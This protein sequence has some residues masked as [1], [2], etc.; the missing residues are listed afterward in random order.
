MAKAPCKKTN[1]SFEQTLWDTADKLR[2]ALPDNYFS[3]L[4]IDVS[5]LAEKSVSISALRNNPA[6]HFGDQPIAVLSHNKPAGYV[7]GAELFEEMMK[8]IGDK[9]AACGAGF[10]GSDQL[11]KQALLS[12]RKR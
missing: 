7:L 9:E 12:L 11:L 3:R 4:G 5:K 2:G 10:T 6:Q 8:L 1:K